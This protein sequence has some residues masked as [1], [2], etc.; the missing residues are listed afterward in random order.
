M[1]SGMATID[2]TKTGVYEVKEGTLSD[3]EEVLH[4]E[5]FFPEP[6]RAREE[7]IRGRFN[8]YPGLHLV[9]HCPSRSN[10]NREIVAYLSHGPIY[11]DYINRILSLED[12]QSYPPDLVIFRPEAFITQH[13]INKIK[14]QNGNLHGIPYL[15]ISMLVLEDHQRKSLRK[16]GYSGRTPALL[17]LEAAVKE[18][19]K[20]G[21]G[22]IYGVPETNASRKFF[23]HLDVEILRYLKPPIS[24]LGITDYVVLFTYPISDEH[25]FQRFLRKIEERSLLA[26]SL[27]RKLELVKTS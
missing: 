9:E 14:A 13:E 26:H 25:H 8:R 19:K 18:A 20:R 3:I 1:V 11:P 21:F 2:R 7:V 4:L 24:L 15:L 6:L 5:G 16:T 27:P 12:Y 17:L 10:G 23:E 22:A